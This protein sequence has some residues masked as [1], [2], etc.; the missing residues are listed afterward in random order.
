MDRLA[1]LAEIGVDNFALYL[2]HDDK[3][4]TLSAYGKDVITH[5]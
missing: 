2:M 5:V 1:E 4:E 3:E